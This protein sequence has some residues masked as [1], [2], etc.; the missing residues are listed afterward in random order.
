VSNPV[1]ISPNTA[2]PDQ[3]IRQYP[4]AGAGAGMGSAG[5]VLTRTIRPGAEPVGYAGREGNVTYIRI[6][7]QAPR[8]LLA[9][10]LAFPLLL[11]TLATANAGF[12]GQGTL[13]F[14][15]NSARSLAVYDTNGDRQLRGHSVTFYATRST[16]IT[17]DGQA[18]SL[19][20]LQEGDG[21]SASGLRDRHGRMIASQ[22]AATSPPRPDGPPARAPGGCLG[23]Y[24]PCTPTL[25]PPTAGPALTIT[26]SNYVFD[27]PVAVVPAG[28][29]V[30][31]KNTDAV[32]HTFS[33]NHLDSGILDNGN[34]FTVEFTTPGT[35]R[36]YCAIHTY[37]NGVLE[38]E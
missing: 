22:V 1:A 8:L 37:M 10:S 7:R 33:G 29:L 28:T 21:I 16:K 20:A 35:Y 4:A 15:D 34:S 27:P 32:P 2:Q 17:R 26:I 36:F 18:S 9:A 38:V 6:R 25:P 24:L 23:Y 11:P 31:V 13:Q 5:S 3:S 19:G 14:V 30:T 12:S